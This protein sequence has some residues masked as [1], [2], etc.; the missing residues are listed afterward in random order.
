MNEFLRVLPVF[1]LSF[2]VVVVSA[3][4]YW[5]CQRINKLE[6]QVFHLEHPKPTQQYYDIESRAKG[7]DNWPATDPERKD[8]R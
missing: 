1:I 5:L 4:C 2:A 8:Q 7:D 3:N 6:I